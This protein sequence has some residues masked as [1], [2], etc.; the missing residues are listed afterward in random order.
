MPYDYTAGGNN[1]TNLSNSILRV[2]SKEI[3][4][5]AQ[6]VTRFDQ[7]A[8]QKTELGVTPGQMI[9][10]LR[11]NNLDKG[12][13]LT[14]GTRM[15]IKTLVGSLVNI[16]VTEYGN[17][18]AITELLLHTSFD[19]VMSSASKLLGFDMA[20]V[21]DSLVR[22]AFLTSGNK[23]Y[24]GDSVDRAN[25]LATSGLGTAEIKDAVEFLKTNDA[26]QL[27]AGYY[28]CFAHP[29][30]LRTLR[31]DPNW[32]SAQHYGSP[33]NLFNGEVG[34]IEDVIFVESTMVTS[35]LTTNPYS[36]VEALVSGTA[37]NK[38]TIYQSIFFG[39]N[40]VGRAT[41]L[42][43]EMRDNGIVDFGRE[44]GLAWYGIT[45]AGMLTEANTVIV[46]TC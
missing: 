14:E 6:P 10:M 12:G 44:H 43:V 32:I 28:V 9:S 20:K 5:Y 4:F 3:L 31:D 37:G 40:A 34:R 2:Y 7:F 42:P 30:Q 29:H 45:G 13:A 27:G 11:Y 23:L 36:Y 15:A 19:D 22:D 35:G 33:E 21:I 17:A 46:E 24:A 39:D 41:A 1:T 38:G 18:V 16:Q 26:P 25:I 8:I